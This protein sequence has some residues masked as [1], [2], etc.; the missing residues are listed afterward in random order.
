MGVMVE[1]HRRWSVAPGARVLRRASLDGRGLT[2][3]GVVPEGWQ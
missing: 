2:T 3:A 1:R